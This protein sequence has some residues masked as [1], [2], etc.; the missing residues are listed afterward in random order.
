MAYTLQDKRVLVTGASSGLG[1]AMTE[2]LAKAGATVILTARS[3]EKLDGAVASLARCGLDAHTQVMDVRDEQSIAT[4]VDEVRRR[5]GGLDVLV[6]NAGIGMRTVNLDFLS[7]PQPF[8]KV[9]AAGFR[10][11]IETNL[12]GYFL[13][14]K[15]F[16]A[17][18]LEQGRGKV[19]NITMNHATMRRKGFVPYGPSRA[20]AESLSLIMAEDLREANVTVNMLLPGGATDTGMIPDEHREAIK[21]QFGLLSPAV[22]AD[23]IVFLSSKASD[24]IT[25]ERIAANEFAEWLRQREHRAL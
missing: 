25:G 3:A 6:Y 9:S 19:V 18:F 8:Y 21:A 16:M 24:G 17:L 5:W 2:A 11:L 10:D 22:M 12:T 4:A 15:A 20:A 23:P 1:L 13:V 14:T 7:E